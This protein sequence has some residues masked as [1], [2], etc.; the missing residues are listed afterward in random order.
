[1]REKVWYDAGLAPGAQRSA[2]TYTEVFHYPIMGGTEANMAGKY[3][4]W[5][6]EIGTDQIYTNKVSAI[7]SYFETPS[8]GT[9]VGLVG[10]TQQP[11]D[12]LWTRCE[13]VEPDFV[14]KGEMT[15]VVTGKGY[16]DDVDIVSDPYRFK[17]DTLKVDMREQRREL[18]LRFG[19]NTV[20]GD[21]FMGRVLCS[22]D[23]GDTRSTA[24][25]A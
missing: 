11:G 8:L 15:V 24:N 23:T 20:G 19:S 7:N 22:L 12:N 5:Q 17:E 2:G 9:S 6:H 4:L 1:V 13:R 3:T 10:S 14:Q 18:R 21:Y 25:P 16:A